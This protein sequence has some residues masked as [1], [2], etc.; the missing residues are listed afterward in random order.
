M[1]VSHGNRPSA[2]FP[3]N[4]LLRFMA[5]GLSVT[6]LYVV[7]ALVLDRI[8]PQLPGSVISFVAHALC[9][10]YSYLA[11]KFFTFES[12][13]MH[14]VEGPRFILLTAA[15]FGIATGLAAWLHDFW[16]WPIAIPVVIAA[17]LVPCMNY[18]GMRFFVFANSGSE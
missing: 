5:T 9:G 16:N 18:L 15:G 2:K 14:R 3:A 8:L 17:I 4:Q 11:H 13:G 7:L 6:M 10:I 12:G 1:S